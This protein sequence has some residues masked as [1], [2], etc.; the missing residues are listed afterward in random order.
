MSK[1]TPGP[2]RICWTTTQDGQ[3]GTKRYAINGPHRE[4]CEC[5]SAGQPADEA[6]ALLIAAAPD[7]LAACKA[8]ADMESW[9]DVD[10]D[11]TA[12]RAYAAIAQAEGGRGGTD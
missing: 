12:G 5:R 3:G 1:H 4:V 6:N 2:W 8:L 9:G 7:L 11:S 10:P